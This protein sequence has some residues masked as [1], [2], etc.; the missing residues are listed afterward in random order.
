MKLAAAFR[1]IDRHP[2]VR[3]TMVVVG[4]L[5]MFVVTPLVGAIPG[6]GGIFVFAAGLSL[7]LRYSPWARRLYVRFKRRWPKQGKWTDWGLRRASAKRRAE[8]EREAN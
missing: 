2:A 8:I 5:L 1:S 7:A 3:M 4:C 6:P